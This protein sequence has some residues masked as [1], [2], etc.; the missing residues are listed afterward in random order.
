[1][2]YGRG[3]KSRLDYCIHDVCVDL[4]AFAAFHLRV[5]GHLTLFYPTTDS[6]SEDE[7]PTHPAMRFMYN[8]PQRLSLKFV[9]RLL[10]W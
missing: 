8:L 5:G 7:L 3:D 2:Q 6:F 9:R 10:T 1:M 4:L